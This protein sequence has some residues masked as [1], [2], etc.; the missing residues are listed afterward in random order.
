MGRARRVPPPGS[1]STSPVVSPVPVVEAPSALES[2]GVVWV[3]STEEEVLSGA[4]FIRANPSFR[5]TVVLPERLFSSEPEKMWPAFQ[6]ISSAVVQGQLEPV[7][8]IS[9]NLPLALIQDTELARVSSGPAAALPLRY[10]WPDD[11]IGQIADA[12]LAFKKRWRR[13]AH[14]FRMPAGVFTGTETPMLEKMGIRG[15]LL[16]EGPGRPGYFKGLP[17]GVVRTTVFPDRPQMQALWLSSWI[18]G[19]GSPVADAAF[20][21]GSTAGGPEVSFLSPVKFTALSALPAFQ[22][23]LAA[24][25]T[26]HWTLISEMLSSAEV[27]PIWPDAEEPPPDFSPWIGEPEENNAWELLGMT[28]R[29]VENYKNSGVAN[30]KALDM[31]MREIHNAER[32]EYFYYFGNDYD[33]S[34]DPDLEREFLATLAQ[35]YRLMGQSIPPA[36]L[37]SFAAATPRV[38]EQEAGDTTFV[39][40]GSVLRWTDPAKDDRGPGDYFYPTA[41]EFPPGAWD[42][43]S[44]EMIEQEKTVSFVFEFSAMANPKNAPYGFSG[45]LVDVYI[46]INHLPGAGNESLLSG[47]PG[48]VETQNAWEYALSLD[49]WGVGVYQYGSGASNRRLAHLPVRKVAVSTVRVDVP[50]AL[51]RGSPDRWRCAVVVMGH[52]PGEV[53]PTA[54]DVPDRPMRVLSEPGPREFGGAWAGTAYAASDR[55]APPFIDLIVP[56]Q[57]TQSQVL[58]IYKQGREVVLPFLSPE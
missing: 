5:A 43:L 46:D 40:Q 29:A 56:P 28:R 58:S 32:G 41:A 23:A 10:A 49:G 38:T 19:K 37:Q 7:L 48:L 30:V 42:I 16:T 25:T 12:Q 52:E 18:S 13:P 45:P 54:R 17:L 9:G 47:R 6:I 55:E 1:S 53:S 20:A 44:F 31:A 24:K 26:F 11:V 34:R 51:L 27:F 36:L 39:R 50:K 15:V 8:D 2:V 4:E 57:Q 33:S 14:T 35:V 3:P 22:G 21:G